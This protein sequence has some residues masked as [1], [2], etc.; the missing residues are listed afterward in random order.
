MNT[1]HYGT[2]LAS[3]FATVNGQRVL[4]ALCAFTFIALSLG[5]PPLA[6]ASV[7]V[8]RRPARS[9]DPRTRAAVTR[10]DDGRA[11]RRSRRREPRSARLSRRDHGRPG[12]DPAAHARGDGPLRGRLRGSSGGRV[13]VHLRDGAAAV[14]S[15]A[16]SGV[17]RHRGSAISRRSSPRSTGS[18][19]A[20][21]NAIPCAAP[22]RRES[23]QAMRAGVWRAPVPQRERRR[24]ADPLAGVGHARVGRRR[25]SSRRARPF[26]RRRA[27]ALVLVLDLQE[28]AASRCKR[29]HGP[30]PACGRPARRLVEER[31]R[32]RRA[33]VRGPDGC[34]CQ[35]DAGCVFQDPWF[36]LGGFSMSARRRLALAIVALPV[37]FYAY[38][39]S[40]SDSGGGGGNDDAPAAVRRAACRTPTAARRTWTA[41]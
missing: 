37:A 9:R 18:R 30:R 16:G 41:A 20:S 13:P 12:R 15:P 24:G 17:A 2:P 22:G 10:P 40:S 32:L 38:A 28:K 31:R 4:Y 11:A 6:A 19:R 25:R 7:L 36:P 1:P 8:A 34:A 5:A 26:P 33:I 21:T 14:A 29:Q 27:A 39:C 23:Q 35:G 3:F